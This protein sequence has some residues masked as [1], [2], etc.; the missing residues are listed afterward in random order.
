[1]KTNDGQN[2]VS[3]CCFPFSPQ[4]LFR[5][6]DIFA[7][8]C[9]LSQREQKIEKVSLPISIDCSSGAA[10]AALSLFACFLFVCEERER[11]NKSKPF[12]ALL[13]VCLKLT[14]VR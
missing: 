1:M 13:Y 5:F 11:V 6:T 8:L 7:Y 4:F 10:S 14:S 12:F 9:Y 2:V 3:S